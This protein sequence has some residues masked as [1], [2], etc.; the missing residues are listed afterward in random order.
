MA[1]EKLAAKLVIGITLSSFVLSCLIALGTYAW[2][3]RELITYCIT[4]EGMEP[5]IPVNS[6][7]WARKFVKP[8]KNDIVIF[9]Y[10]SEMTIAARV[11]GMEGDKLSSDSKN[12]QLLINGEDLHARTLRTSDLTLLELQRV[13]SKED[14]TKL[15]ELGELVIPAGIFLM[16]GDNKPQNST[17]VP[18][19]LVTAEELEAV[20]LLSHP[21]PRGACNSEPV[22]L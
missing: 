3:S 15:Q 22:D 1:K 2:L 21:N 19:Y 12:V 20:H 16:Q 18:T 4:Q 13:M 14:L 6:L 11:I 7:V 8:A 17:Q 5:T 9:H 10:N